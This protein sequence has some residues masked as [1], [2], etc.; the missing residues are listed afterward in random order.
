MAPDPAPSRRRL[1]FSV[2]VLAL[3]ACGG[4]VAPAR[5]AAKPRAVVHVA[6]ASASAPPAP[7]A[8]VPPPDA[9]SGSL[10][11]AEMR[12]VAIAS[13]TWRESDPEGGSSTIE[14]H[15]SGWVEAYG[16][17]SCCGYTPRMATGWY[18]VTKTPALQRLFDQAA[19]SL[20]ES[21][22]AKPARPD[23]GFGMHQSTTALVDGK[24]RP[25]AGALGGG[26]GF[27]DDLGLV[28]GAKP[29]NPDAPGVVGHVPASLR[30][31]HVLYR[32]DLAEVPHL[33][34]DQVKLVIGEMRA[35]AA[36]DR[37]LGFLEL[38]AAVLERVDSSCVDL[39][40][41]LLDEPRFVG[42]DA[43]M[44]ALGAHG[45]AARPY[46]AAIHRKARASDA[47]LVAA[48]VALARIGGADAERWL[49]AELVPALAGAPKERS[50]DLY[51]RVRF[52][53]A[54]TSI[55]SPL[56]TKL[57]ASR[58]QPELERRMRAA[59]ARRPPAVSDVA[60]IFGAL[61]PRL[62]ATFLARDVPRMLERAL[63][64]KDVGARQ[65]ALR[66]MYE[67]YRPGRCPA[68]LERVLSSV[69]DASVRPNAE[70]VRA[71]LCTV[72]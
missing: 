49:S 11:S 30:V 52:A 6:S 58:V 57:L 29:A 24:E 4:A 33:T 67:I 19:A 45:A 65:A 36:R 39:V 12:T 32:G 47:T 62:P 43:V 54:L 53:R 70:E 66:A 5:P 26:L 35:R 48:S 64:Q 34:R 38:V 59:L 51:Y 61:G 16:R 8:T 44:A 56:A 22:G 3:V 25:I 10:E 15:P 37:D 42:T 20:A 13:I 69:T 55:G 63:A 17:R 41:P 2:V 68:E 27:G 50:L 40:A 14:V 18:R 31:V 60:E 21:R 46:A 1:V 72:H 7:T 71:R 23:H 9:A 28:A